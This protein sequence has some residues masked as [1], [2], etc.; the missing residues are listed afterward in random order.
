M[1]ISKD[2]VQVFLV[3]VRLSLAVAG[4]FGAGAVWL[5]LGAASGAGAAWLWL[6]L[7]CMIVFQNEPLCVLFQ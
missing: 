6:G 3:R 2:F 7:E 5:W 4:R 1:Y